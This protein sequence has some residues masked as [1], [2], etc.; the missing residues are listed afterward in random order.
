M[1]PLLPPTGLIPAK[2][3]PLLLLK[4]GLYDL[5]AAS[6]LLINLLSVCRPAAGLLSPASMLLLLTRPLKA[7]LPLGDAAAAAASM[8]LLGGV[9]LRLLRLKQ[10][11]M[12]PWCS[13]EGEDAELMPL[14]VLLLLALLLLLLME[15]TRSTEGARDR[16]LA[17]LL[18][19][20]MSGT[21]RRS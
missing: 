6:G 4:A 19:P 17:V 9:L 13:S 10:L 2:A 12:L 15:L 18:L 20:T 14:S 21:T 3:P 5:A 11:A 1:L 8:L 7:L 16:L